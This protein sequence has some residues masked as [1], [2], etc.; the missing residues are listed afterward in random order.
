MVVVNYCM[1]VLVKLYVKSKI[2][3]YVRRTMQGFNCYRFGHMAKYCRNKEVC[4]ICGELH[5]DEV[6]CTQSTPRCANGKGPHKSIDS[7]CSV[8][9]KNKLLCE[10]MAY[11]NLS[12]SEARSLIFGTPRAPKPLKENFPSLRDTD[13]SETELKTIYKIKRLTV[14]LLSDQLIQ[15][16]QSIRII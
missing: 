8:F 2:E 10:K 16:W 6:K 7:I 14:T 1:C 3:P 15:I 12:F 13:K 5:P 9:E 4:S 11:V